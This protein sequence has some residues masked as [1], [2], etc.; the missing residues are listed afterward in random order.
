MDDPV[1]LCAERLALK[2]YSI[3]E[4]ANTTGACAK[5]NHTLT[6]RVARNLPSPAV[7]STDSI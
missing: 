1:A 4:H 2:R 3:P 5:A 7:A 6:L